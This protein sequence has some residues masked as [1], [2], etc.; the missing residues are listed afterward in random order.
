[1]KRLFFVSAAAVI[2]LLGNTRWASC[3]PSRL[4][5][6]QG[7]EAIRLCYDVY[8]IGKTRDVKRT[9]VVLTALRHRQDKVRLSRLGE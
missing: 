1:M 8:W 4:M 2:L 9:D 3:L 7:D 6:L 5:P